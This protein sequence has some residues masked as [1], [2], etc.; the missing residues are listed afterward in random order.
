MPND[1]GDPERLVM[2]RKPKRPKKRGSA[3]SDGYV[4]IDELLADQDEIARRIVPDIADVLH[5]LTNRQI[6]IDEAVAALHERKE[7]GT[8]PSN[9][10]ETEVTGHE[11]KMA[12]TSTTV[13]KSDP[14]ALDLAV[15]AIVPSL[16][17]WYTFMPATSLLVWAFAFFVCLL[18]PLPHTLSGHLVM[19]YAC[20]QHLGAE[21]WSDVAAVVGAGMA[22]F[23]SFDSFNQFTLPPSKRDILI[24]HASN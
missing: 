13:S 23:L 19:F 8:L 4:T 24:K 7:L 2:A 1:V 12:P 16:V 14:E 20:Y 18:L 11:L 3:R 15:L 6:T 21:T 10:T 9:P 5:D 17:V 22:M